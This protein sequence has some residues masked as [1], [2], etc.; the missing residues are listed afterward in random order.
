MSYYPYKI[1]CDMDGVL[2][3]FEKGAVEAINIQLKSENP[4]KPELAAKVIKELGR[5]YITVKDI[6]KYSPGK[7]SAATKYMYYLVHDDV[8]F[9]ANLE[10][11]PG[12]KRLWS[13]IRQFDPDILTSPMD[14]KGHN[15]SLEGKAIWVERNLGL[16]ANKINFAHDKYKFAVSKDGKPNVL[17][18]DFE[19][20]VKPFTEAGGIGILHVG[21]KNTIK[22]L[23]LLKD[24]EETP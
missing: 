6:Q 17:I 19:T 20:K 12:G 3:N 4:K 2:C 1:Y 18:D 5:N 13:Y 16:D 14:K 11:Q 7:S 9:W 23:E 15:E 21:S 24:S 22:I 8:D 10:W